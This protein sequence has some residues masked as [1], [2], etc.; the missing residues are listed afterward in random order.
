MKIKDLGF[1]LDAK[2]LMS[3]SQ[4]FVK[5]RKDHYQVYTD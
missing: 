3:L 5:S 4:D 2:S 1:D